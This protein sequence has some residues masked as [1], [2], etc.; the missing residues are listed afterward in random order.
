MLVRGSASAPAAH[1]GGG[2][3]RQIVW[4]RMTS[5][6][7]IRLKR[8]S[9]AA[10]AVS[11]RRSRRAQRPQARKT[12]LRSSGQRARRGRRVTAS[13]RRRLRGHALIISRR[14]AS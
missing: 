4:P 3:E 2:G 1:D 8:R 12:V 14:A 10:R 5:P 13:R 9:R 11:R 6:R 7:R